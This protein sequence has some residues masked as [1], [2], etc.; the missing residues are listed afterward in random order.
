[1]TI[2]NPTAPATDTPID[3]LS[4]EEA[5]SQLESIVAA[6][7]GDELTLETAITLYESG[8]SL[9]R[10]CASLLEKADLR[11]QQLAGE[12]LVDFEP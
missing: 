2:E 1:M 11:V 8:Q 10:R 9:I 3:Q 6:L 5:F 7:E 12:E 4:Y